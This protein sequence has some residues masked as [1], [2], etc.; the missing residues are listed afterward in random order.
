MKIPINKI[1]KLIKS[2]PQWSTATAFTLILYLLFISLVLTIS[3]PLKSS[4]VTSLVQR[5]NN[6]RNDLNELG[7]DEQKLLD[8]ANGIEEVK[9]KSEILRSSFKQ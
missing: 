5:G 1:I 8:K 4:K 9:N 6:F 2:T 3:F 7:D